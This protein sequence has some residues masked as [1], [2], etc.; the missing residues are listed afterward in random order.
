M[1]IS[2]KEFFRKGLFT[3][4]DAVCAVAGVTKGAADLS[5]KD[6]HAPVTGESMVAVAFN[7][8]C[9]ARNCGCFAC[10]DRCEALAIFAVMGE[11]IRIATER[12]TGCGTCEYVCPVTPK[13][14]RL[15]PRMNDGMQSAE[16]A[17]I[18]R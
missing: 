17:D 7:E 15:V 2:R 5:A 18:I 16:H 10:A 9:L 13:A 4:G 6:E 1:N 11:G 14:V 12:C 8:N 3:L